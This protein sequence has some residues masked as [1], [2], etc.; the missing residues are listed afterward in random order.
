MDGHGPALSAA[1]A[2]GG[3]SVRRQDLEEGGGAEGS[4]QAPGHGGGYGATGGE[5]GARRRGN[6]RAV[7]AGLLLGVAAV[8]AVAMLGTSGSR[9]PGTGGS[10]TPGLVSLA[11]RQELQ[12][13][14]EEEGEGDPSVRTL[15]QGTGPN[16]PLTLSPEEDPEQDP[17]AMDVDAQTDMAPKGEKIGFAMEPGRSGGG[18]EYPRSAKQFYDHMLYNANLSLQENKGWRYWSRIRVRDEVYYMTQKVENLIKRNYAMHYEVKQNLEADRSNVKADVDVAQAKMTDLVREVKTVAEKIGAGLTALRQ[19]EEEE[20]RRLEH[21]KGHYDRDLR[22]IHAVLSNQTIELEKERHDALRKAYDKQLAK[23]QEDVDSILA[24]DRAQMVKNNEESRN[25]IQAIQD[26]LDRDSKDMSDLQ[27]TIYANVEDAKEKEISDMQ[28]VS[29]VHASLQTYLQH[30]KSSLDESLQKQAAIEAVAKANQE[31]LAEVTTEVHSAA[32]KLDMLQQKQAKDHEEVDE[33]LKS[34]VTTSD[35][36]DS[37]LT[38]DTATV[39]SLKETVDQFAAESP[40][41]KKTV[42]G[43]HA[44]LKST[45]DGLMNEIKKADKLKQDISDLQISMN[46]QI[47]DIASKIDDLGGTQSTLATSLGGQKTDMAN[48]QTR[49]ATLEQSAKSSSDQAKADHDRVSAVVT[50]MQS[51][52]TTLLDLKVGI[53]CARGTLV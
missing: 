35:G 26:Q 32:F 34:L 40:E 28:N 19:A 49:I 17:G 2:A 46:T 30:M 39:A 21:Y 12:S 1:S 5:P 33:K 8:A 6:R 14:L 23:M 48:M 53:Y 22:R 47:N 50:E 37:K 4:Q 38:T 13:V 24:E 36:L 41:F 51:K 16:A 43:D 45:I 9:A 52:L 25:K 27:R 31:A 7:A 29:A 10:R 18:L 42:E 44:A 3:E 11:S 15:P 20:Q